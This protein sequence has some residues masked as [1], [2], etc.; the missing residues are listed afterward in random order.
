MSQNILRLVEAVGIYS[1][2][3]D[4][5]CLRQ[6]ARQMESYTLAKLIAWQLRDYD[7]Y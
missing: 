7:L 5:E 2:S 1:L 3:G 4:E 6:M